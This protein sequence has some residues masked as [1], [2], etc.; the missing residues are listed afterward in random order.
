MKLDASSARAELTMLTR[1]SL[2]LSWARALPAAYVLWQRVTGPALELCL[3]R[4]HR[5]AR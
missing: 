5:L 3:P 2:A 4:L 1:L